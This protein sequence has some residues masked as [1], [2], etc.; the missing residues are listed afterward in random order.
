MRRSCITA[1]LALA[2]GAGCGGDGEPSGPYPLVTLPEEAPRT[3]TRTEP[4]G[5]VIV[6]P[7]KPTETEVAPSKACERHPVSG[8]GTVIAP[9]RPGLRAS[10]VG[11]RAVELHWSF[12]QLPLP[13]LPHTLRASVDKNDEGSPPWSEEVEIGRERSGTV[14]VEVPDFM[15]RPDVALASATTADGRRS[16]VARVLI[17]R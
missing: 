6:F 5:A 12:D 1:A 9:P 4:G 2:L 13:C 8:G 15:P 7:P 17:D 3:I 16:H 14:T 11:P 10:A